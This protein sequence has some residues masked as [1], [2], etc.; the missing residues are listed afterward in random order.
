MVLFASCDIANT[1][2]DTTDTEKANETSK[3]VTTANDSLSIVVPKNFEEQEQP[4]MG[5]IYTAYGTLEDKDGNDVDCTMYVTRFFHVEEPNLTYNLFINMPKSVAGFLFG[6]KA[7]YRLLDDKVK[8][9]DS[10][11]GIMSKIEYTNITQ[12]LAY[13][14]G[15]GVYYCVAIV[16]FGEVGVKDIVPASILDTISIDT[17]AEK[18]A[19][20]GFSMDIDGRVYTSA[21]MNGASITMPRDWMPAESFTLIYPGNILCITKD[22]NHSTICVRAVKKPKIDDK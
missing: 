17:E 22:D 18:A 16:I 12:Y 6:G 8:F 10:A 13:I 9:G 3:L 5:Q 20:A 15:D 7:E 4:T 14:E 11:R 21:K 1:N 2:G 19:V